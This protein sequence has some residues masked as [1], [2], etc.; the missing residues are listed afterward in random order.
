LFNPSC[1]V[2]SLLSALLI[3]LAIDVGGCCCALF[4]QHSLFPVLHT[5]VSPDFS[6]S[7]EKKGRRAAVHLLRERCDENAPSSPLLPLYFPLPRNGSPKKRAKGAAAP[8]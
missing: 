8:A 2:I 4:R 6:G 5:R 7:T 1:A 3:S